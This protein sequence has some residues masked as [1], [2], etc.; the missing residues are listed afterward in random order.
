[1]IEGSA[2]VRRTGRLSFPTEDLIGDGRLVAHLGRNGSLRIFFGPGRRVRLSDGTE[3]R[4]KAMI[5]GRHIVPILTSPPGTIAITGPLGAKRSYGI[6]LQDRG[7]ALVP[8]TSVGIARPRRWV[9]RRHEHRIAVLDDEMRRL[10]TAE[11]MPIAA[12]LMAYTLITH[13]IPGETRLM[14]T[15][16]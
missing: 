10:T 4:I 5:S 1:M 8:L 14:P 6:T 15:G 2:I 12:V 16:E 7:Y 13:G 11:P 9:I 3:W